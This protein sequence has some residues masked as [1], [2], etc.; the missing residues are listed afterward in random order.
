M[1]KE[2][3]MDSSEISTVTRVIDS[4]KVFCQ[5]CLNLYLKKK[6]CNFHYNSIIITALQN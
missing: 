4:L 6:S 2:N 5:I 1:F 3:F